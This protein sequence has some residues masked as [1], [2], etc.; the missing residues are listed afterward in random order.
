MSG[1]NKQGNGRQ[2]QAPT[3]ETPETEAP[4]VPESNVTTV[5]PSSPEAVATILQAAIDK[6]DIAA[7]KPPAEVIKRWGVERNIPALI[8]TLTLYGTEAQI[9]R[10]VSN[11][12]KVA[13][14]R[15]NLDEMQSKAEALKVA[16]K[17]AISEKLP[18]DT[19]FVVTT[20]KVDCGEGTAVVTMRAPHLL[21]VARVE[22]AKANLG[23]GSFTL[24][25][26][27]DSLL[28]FGKT[29]S[30]SQSGD[31][32]VR[33]LFPQV[34]GKVFGTWQELCDAHNIA[35]GTVTQG[36]RETAMDA[37]KRSL[38]DKIVMVAVQDEQ[39]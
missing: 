15:T 33:H 11:A 2:V 28:R 3:A 30:A 39:A 22:I 21:E 35:S 19:A 4:Q 13:E 8:E 31:S 14:T 18:K 24:D 37:A 29:Q 9:Q 26:D 17:S 20:V 7:G 25:V 1:N 34:D 32:P 16:L 5:P 36:V 10:L 38:G 27:K 6:K 12:L 23:I